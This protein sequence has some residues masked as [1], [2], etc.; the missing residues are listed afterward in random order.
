MKIR[1]SDLVVRALEDE[2]IRFAFGIPGT[3]NIELYDALERSGRV[4]PILVTDEQSATFMADAVSRTTGTL[5]C[6]NVVPGAGVTHGLSG[7][8]E[9]FMDNVPMLLLTCGIRRDT[10]RA[11]QLHDVDQLAVLAPI[12][13][14]TFRPDRS[15]EIYPVLR[16]ACALARSGAPGPVAVEIPANLYLLTDEVARIDWDGEPPIPPEPDPAALA[17]AAALLNTARRP[18]LYV[19]NGAK[20]AAELVREVA[21]R[22]GAPVATTIQ[23]KG[24][25]PE[26]HPL[27]LWCG[28]GRSAPPF[29]RHASDGCDAM[30][31]VGC[32]FG[33]VATGSYGLEPPETLIHVDIDPAVPGRNF[34]ARVPVTA[35]AGRFLELL[36]PRL[37]PRALDMALVSAMAGG[38]RDVIAGWEAAPSQGRV[39]PHA[40]FQ[41]VQRAARPDAIY[42]TDSGNGT[43]LSME[44]LRLSRPGCFIG[45]VDYSCMGYAPPAA[46]GAAIANPGRDVVALAGDGALL[47]TGLEM[48]TASANKAA[49]IF[50]VLRDRELGQ[51]AAFQRAAMNRDTCSL[52]PDYDTAHLAA[53]AGA[54]HLVIPDDASLAALVPKAFQISRDG[55]VVVADVMID[56]SRPTY[57]TK[58]VVATNFWRLP[59]SERVRM[60]G[61]AV[62]RRLG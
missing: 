44:H 3:H 26:G 12:T 60:A 20:G 30:L 40:F 9:A 13:K 25:F 41:A 61:R 8:A 36:L 4:T 7:V 35:D 22:L 42:V 21:E 29:V 46:V 28:L 1:G 14:G 39:T 50:F 58:G 37:V 55:R 11:F 49:P 23:G 43:F 57:F 56:Y 34:P 48:L 18:L 38:H 54:E 6:A 51:I 62:A 32:R 24:V 52:L 33:E 10:G 15:D 16:Q 2:G 45:P 59:W 19:G 17:M 5:G 27:W 31:A 47:M 53:F